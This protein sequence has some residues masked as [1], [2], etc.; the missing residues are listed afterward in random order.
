MNLK[1]INLLMIK[2]KFVSDLPF[3]NIEE[4][5]EKLTGI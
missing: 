2:I 3:D 4:L 5:N 1:D